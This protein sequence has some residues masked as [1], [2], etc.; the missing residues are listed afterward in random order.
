MRVLVTGAAGF[1][2]SH[3]LV[4]LLAA[5]HGV[6]AVD[7]FDN[8]DPDVFRRVAE[9]ASKEFFWREC[10]VRDAAALESVLSEAGPVD[11]CIHFAGLKAVGESVAE[12]LRYYR[13]NLAATFAL[14]QVLPRHGCK[15][16]AFSSSA[17]VYG[18]SKNVPFEESDEGLGCTNPYARTGKGIGVRGIE[19]LGILHSLHVLPAFA[20]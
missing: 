20:A 10:D 8:S 3:T 15:R 14:L 13:H 19:H 16:L 4:E 9:L 18:K 5:G 1:I 7:N 12:P 17:T 11:A 2:G 6:V